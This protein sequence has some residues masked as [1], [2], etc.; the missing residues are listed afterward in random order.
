MS[1]RLLIIETDSLK[2]TQYWKKCINTYY[3]PKISGNIIILTC[4]RNPFTRPLYLSLVM[5]MGR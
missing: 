1:L 2:L 5:I 4:K 3:F